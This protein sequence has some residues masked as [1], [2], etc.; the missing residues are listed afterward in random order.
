MLSAFE[1]QDKF[2]RPVS[3]NKL[4]DMLAQSFCARVKVNGK[5]VI[6]SLPLCGKGRVHRVKVGA[7]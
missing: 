6:E 5:L 2:F 1:L 4:V 7:D 3:C